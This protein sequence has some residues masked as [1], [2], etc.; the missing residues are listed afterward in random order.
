MFKR[1]FSVFLFLGNFIYNGKPYD[2]FTNKNMNFN[3]HE[4]QY[5]DAGFHN[6][7]PYTGIGCIAYK[8]DDSH[9]YLVS[10]QGLYHYGSEHNKCYRNKRELTIMKYNIEHDKVDDHLLLGSNTHYNNHYTR[11]T[12]YGYTN[13]D[14]IKLDSVGNT[15]NNRQEI[16]E[17]KGNVWRTSNVMTQGCNCEC[18]RKINEYGGVGS[19]DIRVCG[20]TSN[21]ILYMVGGNYLGCSSNYNTEPSIVRINLNDFT[22][23]DRTLIKNIQNLPSFNPSNANDKSYINRPADGLLD[24]DDILYLIFNAE[25]TGLLKLGIK[26]T[27]INIISNFQKSY[28]ESVTN[29]NDD[30]SETISIETRYFSFLTKIR[31]YDNFKYIYILSEGGDNTRALRGYY[32]ATLTNENTELITMEGIKDVMDFK[33]D[34]YKQKIYIAS[35]MLTTE[36]YQMDKDL[37][38]IVISQNC[39]ID[40]L[41]ISPEWG[42]IMS[43]ELDYNTGFIYISLYSRYNYIGF[44][45]IRTKDFHIDTQLIYLK[46]KAYRHN[47]VMRDIVYA[48]VSKLFPKY[49]KFILSTTPYYAYMK[50]FVSID[51]LGCAEGRGIENDFC[52]ICPAGKFSNI[53]GASNCIDC[54]YGH[55]TLN[56]ES[57]ECERCVAGK[58]ANVNGSS[59]CFNCNQG[60]YSEKSGSRVCKNCMPGRYSSMISSDTSSLCLECES[61]KISSHGDSSCS[62]CPRGKFSNGGLQCLDCPMGKYNNIIG[63]DKIEKCLDC[64]K[65]KYNKNVGADDENDCIECPVGKYN[66][67]LGSSSNKSCVNCEIGK[68]KTNAMDRG[69][70][71]EYCPVGKYSEVGYSE[72]K[73]CK[74]GEYIFELRECLKCA[75]GTY[76]DVVG[77]MDIKE[78]KNCPKGKY[79][80]NVGSNSSDN[81]ISCARGKYSKVLGSSNINDCLKCEPGKYRGVLDDGGQDCKIC[82]NG[83]FSGP[84]KFRCEFC[85][86]GKYSEGVLASD[87][88]KCK[89]CPAGKYR[90]TIGG[91]SLSD[92]IDC[93][94]GKF[95]GKS[96]RKCLG[97]PNGKYNNV[98]GSIQCKKCPEGKYTDIN[99]TITCDE[100]RENSEE[101]VESTK[102]VC[103]PGTYFYNG[104]CLECPVNMKCKRDSRIETLIVES[105]YWRHSEKSL[106]VY[107]CRKD[108]PCLGG[109]I[110][111]NSNDLCNVGHTGPLCDVCKNGYAKNEGKCFKC[112]KDD[113]SKSIAITILVPFLAMGVLVFMIKTA[114]PKE[115]KKE[116]LSGVIKILMNYA[117]VFSLASSF[118]INWPDKLKEFFERTKDFS[119]PRVSFYSSDC[120]FGWS[121]YDKLF[122]YLT[123]PIFY[124][125]ISIFIIKI[126]AC[127]YEKTRKEAFDVLNTK[128]M[129]HIERIIS[130]ENSNNANGNNSNGNNAN[131]NIQITEYERNLIL[132]SI[133][134]K[135]DSILIELDMQTRRIPCIKEH[136][137]RVTKL[138]NKY[139]IK[140]IFSRAWTIT[141]I[142]V[143]TFLMYP[144][145]IKQSLATISCKQYG[146]KSYLIEDLSVECYDSTYNMY[147]TICYLALIVY[148][149]GIPAIGFAFLYKYRYNLYDSENRYQGAAPLSFLFLGYRNQVWYYEFIVMM[150]KVVLILISV[151]LKNYSRYQMIVASLL[152]QVAFFL[153]VFLK[154][155]DTITNYGLL[156]NRLE[157]MSLLALV[158]TLNSGLFF[159]TIENNFNLGSFET[160]LIILLFILNIFVFVQFVY[161]IHSLGKNTVINNVKEI[162]KKVL[163]EKHKVYNNEQNDNDYR[164]RNSLITTLSVRKNCC[165][166]KVLGED[167]T[168]KIIGWAMKEK[169]KE[170]HGMN[171]K[172]EYEEEMFNGFFDEKDR[173]TEDLN[174]TYN[175]INGKRQIESLLFNLNKIKWK[176]ENLEKNRIWHTI[177]TNRIFTELKETIN[178]YKKMNAG[179]KDKIKIV[180]SKYINNALT[181]NRLIQDISEKELL[182]LCIEYADDKMEE[183]VYTNPGNV[184]YNVE[185]NSKV[186]GHLNSDVVQTF[187]I[188]LVKGASVKPI[189]RRLTAEEL[190]MPVAQAMVLNIVDNQESGDNPYPKFMDD[191]NID[192]TDEIQVEIKKLIDEMI[193][194]IVDEKRDDK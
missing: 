121:Y 174:D 194:K 28:N 131:G 3:I 169:E 124:I 90:S 53:I 109:I 153:H 70:E 166:T 164:R 143:G 15:A 104:E 57:Q 58:F 63:I 186:S 71:C 136:I 6:Q 31:F 101:N 100:C 33:I 156:C 98:L 2:Y 26:N 89:E 21:N 22:F 187:G 8:K 43:F 37:N 96:A 92:C 102:C 72:C 145:I 149:I 139:P 80:V 191:G 183:V 34:P 140:K 127:N 55:S 154:P 60:K 181:Y 73:V 125:A 188:E 36:M 135:Y 105:S 132:K 32:N 157:N 192:E 144:T 42:P 129:E 155:Y 30:G 69:I 29:F 175:N 122:V 146:E 24:E 44:T 46:E 77:I 93:G 82:A 14:Y 112:Q 113:K 141:T 64:P 171:L 10:S 134:I 7:W 119:S 16:C 66:L 39:G 40:F 1:F 54:N 128:F 79:Y 78:C 170:N 61:G 11:Y 118:E 18:C 86:R 151:F 88:I 75:K 95:S 184:S 83:K 65:G 158:V 193:E 123:M 94:L 160:F 62:I 168:N 152:M 52:N 116:A 38:K 177:L 108:Y 13:F 81:C 76:S 117:Q 163:M 138:R 107:P 147:I 120:T 130:L 12:C 97:C 74:K 68:Y 48:N 173:F 85:V 142:V 9:S 182:E 133:N 59:S 179:Q 150:K 111:N 20:I 137:K 99:G 45:K 84:G 25:Y 159:G 176:I 19:D 115:N 17:K 162:S 110:V 185:S 189:N 180:F 91:S 41:K 47:D 172:N 161:H 190:K 106:D 49:G 178:K 5:D 167:R 23:I 114:N 56:E 165:T 87:H 103:V 35:G 27:P 67:L 4:I 148:G 126:I 51:L 50:R